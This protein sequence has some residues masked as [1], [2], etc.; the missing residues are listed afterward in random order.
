MMEEPTQAPDP[1]RRRRRIDADRALQAAK[2]RYSGS[3][4]RMDNVAE[5]MA[6]LGG[7][8]AFLVSHVVWFTIWIL[9][10][11]EISGFIPFD[12]YP[13]GLLT[14]IVSLEAICLSIFIL[15]AQNRASATSEL[16]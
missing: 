8:S 9:M 3:R 13:Y 14:L 10:N 11:T 1:N 2:T 15:M 12:P 7:S 6:R 16:R 4:T 5:A